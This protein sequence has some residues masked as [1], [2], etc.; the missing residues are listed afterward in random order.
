M[1]KTQW[2]KI[3][4]L[5]KNENGSDYSDIV[6]GSIKMISCDELNVYW[7]EVD[8]YMLEGTKEECFQVYNAIKRTAWSMVH[9]SLGILTMTEEVG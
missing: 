3:T 2:S 6:I 5:K 8:G 4:I 7:V 9:N 1:V